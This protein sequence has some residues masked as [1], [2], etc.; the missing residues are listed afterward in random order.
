MKQT[1][2]NNTERLAVK[3][4]L[5]YAPYFKDNRQHDD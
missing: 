1:K 2:P 5:R 3:M 4:A